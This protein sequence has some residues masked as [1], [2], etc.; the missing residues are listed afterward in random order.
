V[1]FVIFT[2]KLTRKRQINIK[3]FP[4]ISDYAAASSE[5]IEQKIM[6]INFHRNKANFIFKSAQMIMDK[7]N[8]QVP[9]TMEE[10][11]QLPGV[12]RKTANV[13]LGDAFGKNE[14]II[15]D[16][17]VKRLAN[18]LGLTNHTD[19]VKIELDLMKIVPQSDWIR[20]SHLLTLYGRYVSTGRKHCRDTHLLGD[21]CN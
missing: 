11:T 8:S 9:Q 19:P 5:K 17:H 20:F 4:Q 6:K 1:K 14:G 7:F 3:S 16:T 13:V 2:S 15:V 18:Q 21:L 10:L 12:A